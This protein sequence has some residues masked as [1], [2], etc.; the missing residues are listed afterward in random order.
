MAGIHPASAHLRAQREL[1]FAGNYRALCLLLAVVASYALYAV[2]A[3]PAL[4][5]AANDC[6]YL[7]WLDS[8]DGRTSPYWLFVYLVRLFQALSLL[9]IIAACL[10]KRICVLNIVAGLILLAALTLWSGDLR[11]LRTEAVSQATI[12]LDL[13]LNASGNCAK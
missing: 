1:V 13:P 3:S 7:V 8:S 11:Q 9:L 6:L 5:Q 10:S 2:L 12:A 4:N